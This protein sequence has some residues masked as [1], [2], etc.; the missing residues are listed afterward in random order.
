MIK[1]YQRF[2]NTILVLIDATMLSA[3]Y[4]IACRRSAG[5]N[6]DGLFGSGL[7]IDLVW[8]VPMIIACFFIM[9]IYSPMRSK[10]F[11]TEA[12]L[13]VRAHLVG[14]VV[15]YGIL[16]ITG[17]HIV[18]QEVLTIFGLLGLYLILVE[19]FVIRKTLRV[20]R[21]RGYNLKH[22]LVVGA[23]ST[24]SAFAEKVLGNR[25]F[26]YNI[27]GFL[28]EDT[29]KHGT[30]VHGRPVLGGD[31]LLGELLAGK[32][33]DEVIIALPV[34]C[35][36]RYKGIVEACEKEGIRV[37]IIPNFEGY[38]PINP[39]I[40]ELDGIPLL[41]IRSIPLDDPFKQLLKRC[42]DVL[43]SLT[44]LIFAGPIMLAIAVGV[45]LSSPGPIF[46]RQERVGLNNQPFNMLKF[47]SMR[48]F[49]D[50][51]A[52]TCWT[53]A[54]DPRKTRFGSFIRKT[55]LDELPQF[56]NV[57]LGD[58][59]VVGPRPERPFFVDQFK[60]K[61]P[62]YMV[63]HQVKP[64]ITGWAQVNGWRGDTSIE[65]R[66]ECDIY[67]IENW[68]VSLDLKIMCATVFKGLVNK[69]AY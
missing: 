60:Q 15:I 39:K 65:R 56:L 49:D 66:I 32:H 36:A 30:E 37:R 46:F 55:S 18:S 1:K 43:I 25:E 48:V 22:I 52:A 6:Q 64:G 5:V 44:A 51:T 42:L 20:V 19:R 54:N 29:R 57:L 8:V 2:F 16:F 12:I 34:I 10:T 47:R 61:V 67:Y 53:T 26:G 35:H 40:D 13:I 68:D 59:S 28:D 41:N 14:I 27:I 58:M 7:S 50:E 69:N 24:G 9:D 3:A 45:K 33:V 38:F 31:N 11:S 23:G 62:K 17:R 21:G 63:K 4:M